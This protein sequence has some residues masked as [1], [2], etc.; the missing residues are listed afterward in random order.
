M[1]FAMTGIAEKIF[2]TPLMAHPA[3]LRALVAGLGPRIIGAPIVQPAAPGALDDWEEPRAPQ[4]PYRVTSSGIALIPVIGILVNRG[5]F[6]MADSSEVRGY[7]TIIAEHKMAIADPEVR[8]IV[9]DYETPGG[10]AWGCMDAARELA[11][12]RG[13]KPIIAAVNAYCFSAGAMAASAADTIFVPESGQFGSIGVVAVHVDQSGFDAK[14]G[15]K[16]EYVYQGDHK[17]DGNP[18]EPLSDG[19]RALMEGE[20]RHLYDLFCRDFAANRR[21]DPA[22]VRATQA[23]C[24]NG[25]DAVAAGIAD[26]VGTITDAIAEAERRAYAAQPKP[27]SGRGP[28]PAG[29]LG[30]GSRMTEEEIAADRAERAAKAE[31][32]AKVKAEAAAA[33]ATKAAQEHASAVAALCAVAGR[34][35]D[36]AKLIQEGLSLEA[37]AHKL[38]AAKADQSSGNHTN[39]AHPIGGQPPVDPNDP[40]GWGK[41]YKRASGSR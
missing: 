22:K 6:D 30:K 38:Q 35:A 29:T 17:V 33:A 28:G 37:C 31:Q 27:P 20:V 23:R 5:R 8:A 11:A 18:H 25:H 10:E 7:D 14:L 12:L 15:V 19:A 2:E 16:V 41:A 39:P 24:L 26:T 4:R 9:A 36:A 40:D 34:P 13:T 1:R 32:E 21:M 3:K